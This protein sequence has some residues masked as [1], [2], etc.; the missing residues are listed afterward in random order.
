MDLKCSI[1]H[2]H[3]FF[4]FFCI[5]TCSHSQIFCHRKFAEG[6]KGT[7]IFACFSGNCAFSHRTQGA[8]RNGGGLF[9]WRPLSVCYLWTYW[10]RRGAEEVWG[11][12]VVIMTRGNYGFSELGGVY[13]HPFQT[14]SY[15][16]PPFEHSD[17]SGWHPSDRKWLSRGENGSSLLPTLH[18]S[19]PPAPSLQLE[20]EDRGALDRRWGFL[21]SQI[22]NM[23]NMPN[24]KGEA[25]QWHV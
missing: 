7:K 1:I 25:H 9:L 13:A 20:K 11:R 19:P 3:F 5:C 8:R 24:S 23:P 14:S 22:N 4:F 2:K 16:F 15:Y 18:I 17:D 12:L 10:R 21:F 6:V